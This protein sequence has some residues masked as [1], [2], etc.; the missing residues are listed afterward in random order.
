V[1]RLLVVAPVLGSLLM[2]FSIAF[3]PA[4]AWSLAA[5][6]GM[7]RAFAGS[8]VGCFVLGLLMWWASRRSR[9]EV[10][11]R[12]GALLVVFGW[13]LVTFV[14][15]PP[16]LVAC[17]QLSFAKVFMETLSG[18]TTT[19][20]TVLSGLD[21]LPQSVNLWRHTLQWFGGMG[22]IVMVVAVLPLLGVGGMQ[23]FRAETPGPMK[24]GKLTPRITQT[25]KFMW[26]GYVLLTLL[27][28]LALWA[29]GMTPFDAVCHALSTVSLGGFSTRDASIGAFDSLRIELVLAVFMVLSTINF[30]THFLALRSRSPAVYLRDLE[31]SSSV[32]LILVSAA[33]ITALL[34]WEQVFDSA[35]EALRHGVFNTISVATSTGFM[36]RDYSQ[37][38]VFAPL[39]M[40][41]LACIASSAGS[42]G[43]GIKMV[44][45]LILLKQA[46]R[47]L[48]RLVHPRAVFPLSINGNPVDERVIY[49]VFGF[50]L[51][52]G[53]TQLILTF[54]MVL[55]G[56]DFDSALSAVVASV[57]NLGPAL[58][59]FGP[60]ENFSSLTD[61]QAVLLAIAMLA[62][63]LEL[64]TFFAVLTPAFWRR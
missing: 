20:A 61:F 25:A 11:P 8:A 21:A 13:L 29:A 47:E 16:L 23:L 26:A 50:M 36:T 28:G 44:R 58:G 38:P 35:I 6:D 60:A 3:L 22:I 4:F 39:W 62:G 48:K 1:L 45:A 31:A 52:W 46:G 19:G 57:N 18:L 56:V 54:V 63:R 51:L 7:H 34:V 59:R 55:T 17:P 41:F 15:M 42:T 9:R 24:E 14:S 5:D 2:L 49:S 10:Q 27:C 40:I 12:D 33:G 37:W 43:G 32:L 30:G 53:A 64:L